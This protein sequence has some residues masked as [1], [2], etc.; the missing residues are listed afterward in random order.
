MDWKDVWQ[1]LT[2][3]VVNVQSISVKNN[4]NVMVDF[5]ELFNPEILRPVHR[6]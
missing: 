5:V 1:A 4:S 2:G 6:T 3:K